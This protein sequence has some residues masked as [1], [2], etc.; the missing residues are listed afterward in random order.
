MTWRTGSR[1]AS[2]DFDLLT[3]FSYFQKD[4]EESLAARKRDYTKMVNHYY[5]LATDF[6]EYVPG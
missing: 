5:D 1:L 2:H 3:T 6:Y 4:N